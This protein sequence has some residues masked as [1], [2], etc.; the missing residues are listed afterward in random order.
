MDRKMLEKQ[1]EK[2][3]AKQEKFLCLKGGTGKVIIYRDNV[4]HPDH[5]VY[6]SGAILLEKGASIGTHEHY[7]D[8]EIWIVI[9]GCVE[10]NGKVMEEGQC[11]ICN[12]GETHSC[13]NLADGDS[14]LG[15]AKKKKAVYDE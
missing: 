1:V 2:G 11:F 8:S 13:I 12:K 4:S 5:E 7:N 14:I 10:V 6:D 15:F 9:S 3:E